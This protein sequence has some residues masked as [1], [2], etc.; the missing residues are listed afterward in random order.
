[1]VED[2]RLLPMRAWK[3]CGTAGLL[4]MHFFPRAPRRFLSYE[5][6]YT[7]ACCSARPATLSPQVSSGPRGMTSRRWDDCRAHRLLNAVHGNRSHTHTHTQPQTVC[8]AQKRKGGLVKRVGVQSPC[9]NTH[10]HTRLPDTFIIS[11]S[12]NRRLK[13]AA[14]ARAHCSLPRP[15]L[16]HSL[17]SALVITPSSSSPPGGAKPCAAALVVFSR[18]YYFSAD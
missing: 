14:N 13:S 8:I 18:L 5:S 1:M 6:K 16:S 3:E 17:P 10:A 2:V 7:L 11:Q 15:P 12:T 4:K 9:A